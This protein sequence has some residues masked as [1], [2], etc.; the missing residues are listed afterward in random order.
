[1]DT[2][3][4]QTKGSDLVLEF[5][6]AMEEKDF[7]SAA[8]CLSNDFQFSGPTPRPVGK[9]DCIDVHRQLLQA[10]PDWRFNFNVTKEDEHEV[11]GKV[12]I[13]GTHTRELTLPMVQNLGTIQATGKKI[14]MPEEN[15]SVKFAGSKISQM[16]IDVPPNGGVAG[17]LSQ[18]GVDAHALA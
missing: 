4:G 3:T 2:R 9:Q 6:H 5:F 17:L 12:R 7:D 11:T 16:H 1:M 8:K 13:T 10:I 15:V 18:M 14:S